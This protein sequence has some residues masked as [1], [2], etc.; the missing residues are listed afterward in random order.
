MRPV[1]RDGFPPANATVA[2]GGSVELVCETVSED[3]AD[4]SVIEW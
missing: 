2:P 4:P 1:L 3:P